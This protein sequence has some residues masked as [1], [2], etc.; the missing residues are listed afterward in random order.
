[1]IFNK[2]ADMLNKKASSVD[3]E[4]KFKEFSA[5]SEEML[6]P[7]AKESASEPVATTLSATATEKEGNIELKL[8]HPDSF[9]DV[10][11]I[12]DYL[13]DGCTVLL[14]LEAVND[15]EVLRMLDF[16]NGVT[17][18]T[19]GEINLVSQNTYVITPHDV[20]V[21]EEEC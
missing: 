12:A 9:A 7:T 5:E 4:I 2:I 14:N 18:T 17:Y 3:E 8:A 13:L 21:S 19:G 15:S 1:M 6:S 11:T 16:L 20:D 10:S